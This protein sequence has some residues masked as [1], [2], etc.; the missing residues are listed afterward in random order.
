MPTQLG[1]EELNILKQKSPYSLPDNPSD[2][3]LSALQIKI[4]FYEG[5]VVL[6]NW[7]KRSIDENN[8]EFQSIEQDITTLFSYFTS[9]KANKAIM[10]QLGRVIDQYYESLEGSGIK[11]QAAKDYADDVGAQALSDAKDYADSGDDTTLAL[12]KAHGTDVI[13]PNAKNYADSK[14][15]D[16]KTECKGY[17]DD[18]G[19]E[20]LESAK[21]YTDSEVSDLKDYTDLHKVD[22]TDVVNNLTDTSTNKPLSANQG[23]VLK[24]HIDS[25]LAILQ[26][27]DTDLDTLQEIVAYIKSHQSLIE[28][29]TTTKV[30]ISDIVDN[31][32]TQVANKPLSAKQG[33]ALKA[34]IDLKVSIED[35]VDNLTSQATNKPVSAKQAYVLKGLIDA[36]SSSK[37]DKSDTDTKA[38]VNSKIST[39]LA[40]VNTMNVIVDQDNSKNYTFQLKIRN[41]EPVLIFNEVV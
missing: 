12:A 7:L 29:I 19:D 26:S 27:P 9:G 32:T 33:Y 20:T 38:E 6:F 17:A 21:S 11:L 8:S 3:G 16:V 14:D 1:D 39:A 10:D 37:A 34:L 15:S 41:G 24:G 4:K 22:K 13:L 28:S 31:L 18:V 35:I 23:R 2:K 40:N 5:L 36:L 25:I 30:N